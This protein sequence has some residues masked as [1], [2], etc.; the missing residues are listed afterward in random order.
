VSREESPSTGRVYGVSRVCDAARTARSSYYADQQRGTLP[1]R[2]L[3]RRGPKPEIPDSRL[4]EL[5]R[6]DLA[7]SPFQGEGHRK[8]WGRLKFGQGLRVGRMRVLRV[9]REHNLLSPY[10]RPRGEVHGHEGR[11]C[12]E[13]PNRMWGADGTKVFT[14]EEGY[15]WVFVA[16]E[17]WNAECMGAHVCKKGDRFAALEPVAQGVRTTFGTVEAEAARGLA[18]RIDYGPQ[19]T[20]DHFQKQIRWWGIAPS[21]AFLSE[22]ETNGVAER[23]IRTL[24]EQVIAGRVFRNL[25]ELRRAVMAFVERYN[26]QWRVEKNGYR[27]PH[28]MRADWSGRLENVA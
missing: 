5:I 17:H 23:F 19:Y 21:F 26:Q 25:E 1:P 20:S 11:I 3:G 2:S 7:T 9:M 4:L 14:L 12:T 27:T 22:P 16:V 8:V 13:A 28:Q 6:E 10:R 18:L 15:G 24:R